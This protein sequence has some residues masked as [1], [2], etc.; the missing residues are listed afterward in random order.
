MSDLM[1][2]DFHDELPWNKTHC[3][4]VKRTGCYNLSRTDEIIRNIENVVEMALINI[5]KNVI[6]NLSL[7]KTRAEEKAALI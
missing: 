7:V 5:P 3:N 2:S 1:Q 4:V 6:L